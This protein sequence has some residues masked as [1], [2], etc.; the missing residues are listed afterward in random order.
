MCS[1]G[2]VE[3]A[4]AHI[5][6]SI[7][8]KVDQRY[9]RWYAIRFSSATKR[10]WRR[11]AP[12]LTAE[13]LEQHIVDCETELD[14]DAESIITNQRYAYISGVVGKSVKKAG[15]KSK[16]TTPTRSTGSSRTGSWRSPFLSLSCS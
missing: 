7:E 5:E 2:S 11:S 12:P 14:D 10:S 1:P 9:L 3:H 16:L 8:G 4:V 15:T 13:A 6:E